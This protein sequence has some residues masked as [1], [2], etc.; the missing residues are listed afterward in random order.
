METDDLPPH[1]GARWLLRRCPAYRTPRA[2]FCY[3]TVLCTPLR[4]CSRPAC[5]NAFFK[6][7]GAGGCLLGA[8]LAEG[9]LPAA[10]RAAAGAARR[11][12]RARHDGS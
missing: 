2:D 8:L 10:E 4:D 7:A 5:A 1:A 3:Y 11:G 6:K 12:S 9:W